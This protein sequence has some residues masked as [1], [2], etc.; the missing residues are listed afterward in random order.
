MLHNSTVH[1]YEY[2]YDLYCLPLSHSFLSLFPLLVFVNSVISNSNT[3]NIIPITCVLILGSRGWYF[4]FDKKSVNVTSVW[5]YALVIL[6]LCL[7]HCTAENLHYLPTI[8]SE[9]LSR[10]SV[11][12]ILCHHLWLTFHTV[13]FTITLILVFAAVTITRPFLRNSI[14]II[15]SSR[16]R[17]RNVS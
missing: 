8:V 11:W 16:Y 15:T 12:I 5:F 1:R 10:M 7:R 3:S 13:L 9:L 2:N 6:F 17:Y 14:I 4:H